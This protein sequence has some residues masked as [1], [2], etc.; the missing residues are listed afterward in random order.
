MRVRRRSHL[1]LARALLSY[2]A[3][4]AALTLLAACG[5]VTL[6]RSANAPPP[7]RAEP[8]ASRSSQPDAITTL[9]DAFTARTDDVT[10]D[11][12]WSALVRYRGHTI[13]FDSGDDATALAHNAQVL[14]VDLREV[15]IAVLSHDHSDHSSGFDYLL[16]VNP[17]VKLYLPAEGNLGG[18]WQFEVSPPVEG[19]Q[20]IAP[21]RQYYRGA[22]KGPRSTSGRYWKANI[23]MVPESREIAPGIVLVATDSPN[24]GLVSRYP[25]HEKE[26]AITPLKE[27]SLVLDTTAGD[28]VLVGCAHS[29]IEKIV[30][31]TKKLRQREVAL[32][33]GGFHLFPYGVEEVR[34]VAMRLRDVLHVKRVAPAHCTGHLGFQAF[35]EVFGE[36]DVFAG[37]GERIVL[38]R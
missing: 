28:V 15:D 11:W 26:A 1:A 32:L 13:L 17:G 12:G 25:P 3:S 5:D 24:L 35:A 38:P 36:R 4:F 27:L 33:V 14:G 18:H 2:A 31:V 23:E 30:G 21:E 8:A 37:L 20:P 10:L 19:M 7:T 6:S 22:R 9:Y 16:S 34:G 29:G